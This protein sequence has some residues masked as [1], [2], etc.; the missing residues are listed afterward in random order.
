MGSENR[1]ISAL[2]ETN[3]FVDGLLVEDETGVRPKTA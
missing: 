2:T 1:P 3:P